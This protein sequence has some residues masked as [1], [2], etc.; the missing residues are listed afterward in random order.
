[1]VKLKAMDA[2]ELIETAKLPGDQPGENGGSLELMDMGRPPHSVLSPRPRSSTLYRECCLPRTILGCWNTSDFRHI[3][4]A[5]KGKRECLNIRAGD[6]VPR[7]NS[8]AG[9]KKV[10]PRVRNYM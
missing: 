9:G 2:Q 10:G 4:R 8:E 7:N 1:M 3:G 6:K 5:E